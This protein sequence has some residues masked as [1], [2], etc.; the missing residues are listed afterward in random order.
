MSTE[1]IPPPFVITSDD[2][3]GLIVVTTAIT[4]SFVWTC[5]LIRIWL[6]FKAREW[7]ADDYVLAAATILASS[8]SALVL[9][10]ATEGL[11]ESLQ[12][13]SG[14]QV[15]R[16]AK[17]DF[18]S[19]ILYILGLFLSKCAVLFL[20]LRLSPARRHHIAS[21]MTVAVSMA[22]AVIAIT[23]IAVPCN[24]SIFWI[25]GPGGC[26]GIITKW[27]AIAAID[28][29]I[30]FAIFFISAFLVAKLNMNLSSKVL[31]VAAFSARLPVIAAA[32]TRLVYLHGTFT[33]SDRTLT[34][35]YYVVCTQWHLGYAIMSSTITGLGPFLR[36]F[37]T[38][39]SKSYHSSSY[40]Q[41][42]GIPAS[43][44]TSGG[45]SAVSG[46]LP[47]TYQ[48]GPLRARKVS[49][50]SPSAEKQAPGN[51][52]GPSRKDFRSRSS[53]QTEML[54]PHAMNLRPDTETVRR[55]TAVSVGNPLHDEDD[56]SS[57]LSEQSRRL[58]ITKRTEVKVEND[59]A[60][61][62]VPV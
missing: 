58:I 3:R 21:W 38:S 24:P 2:K 11:G 52:G 19:Q 22:W 60:S 56:C 59:R 34:G 30:E 18:A 17:D 42:S 14:R 57:T 39:Y 37:S 1:V 6:R 5:Q 28:I 31:V 12:R 48:L 44:T 50:M 46:D 4:L 8:Q 43:Q 33:S 7:K 32:A 53:S 61:A 55:D 62:I 20:Y 41:T 10:I 26:S 45:G 36:P 27:Q 54:S 16:I 13:L 51:G 9:H 49:L 40:A 15:V 25:K 29:M 23:L 35:A 47:G